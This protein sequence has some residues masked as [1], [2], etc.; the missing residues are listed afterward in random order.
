MDKIELV[1]G[2]IDEIVQKELKERLDERGGR[3]LR[4]Y[5]EQVDKAYE[6]RSTLANLFEKDLNSMTNSIIGQLQGVGGGPGAGRVNVIQQDLTSL[7]KL[8]SV[9]F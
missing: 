2:K 9:S 1:K 4:V 7:K 6:N 5:Q 8:I 3:D